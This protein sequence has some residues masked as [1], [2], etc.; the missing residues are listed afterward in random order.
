M[1]TSCACTAAVVSDENRVIPAGGKTE[2]EVGFTVGQAGTTSQLATFLTDSTEHPYIDLIVSAVGIQEL[3][4]FPPQITLYV[5]QAELP[6][7]RK[8]RISNKVP[9]SDS[10]HIAEA[11]SSDDFI[12]C[13]LS[14]GQEGGVTELDINF[15]R[16]LPVT[17]LNETVVLTLEGLPDCE[18]KRTI[19]IPIAGEILPDVRMTPASINLGNLSGITNTRK[20]VVLESAVD[21]LEFQI[22]ELTVSDPNQIE[23]RTAQRGKAQ[24]DLTVSLTLQ[25]EKGLVDEHVEIKMRDHISGEYSLVLPIS[26]YTL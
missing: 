10:V 22:L 3:L 23:C 26:G 21:G 5:S 4:V 25:P 16:G 12:S 11:L 6:T 17:Q 1:K 24:Y 9:E 8:V 19:E 14:K 2:V 7:T 18:A 13:R 15:N 20:Q